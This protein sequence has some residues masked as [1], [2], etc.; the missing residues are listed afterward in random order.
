MPLPMTSW[1]AGVLRR[2]LTGFRRTLAAYPDDASPWTTVPGPVNVTGT[3]VLH[4]TGNLQH[5]LGTVLGH[6]GFVRDRDAEFATR[7]LTREE[8]H[9]HLDATS[10][11]VTAILPALSK[12]DLAAP[13]PVAF[14]NTRVSTGDFLLHLASHLGYHLG[15]AD[16]HRR[17]VTGN[18]SPAG[19]V[20]IEDLS[21]AG[22]D[23]S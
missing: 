1:L 6:T 15:Q 20:L 17:V 7:D 2:D 12:N 9:P 10:A 13:Y 23:P 5:F 8:L 3:L 4:V 22:R 19:L 18:P 14:R 21:S 11:V 16:Y